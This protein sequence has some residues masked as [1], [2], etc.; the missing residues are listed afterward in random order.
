VNF[1]R[2]IG[3]A[4]K[5]WLYRKRI[6]AVDVESYKTLRIVADHEKRTPEEVAS[7]L[8]EAAAHE[9][10]AQ[11]WAARCWEQLSPRQKQI[12]A[13]ICQ[14]DST[15]QI[16]SQL[17]IAQTTVKSHIEIILNK[18]GLNSRV[19]L[20]QLLAPWDLGGYL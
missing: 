14:G 13:H 7:R 18:F 1:I 2:V 3:R 10:D 15:R 19:A 12:A 17:N 4:L 20:R 8:F 9:L 6:F 11:A 16:A 5:H